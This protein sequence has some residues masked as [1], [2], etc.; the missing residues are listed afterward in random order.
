MNDRCFH[1][2][3]FEHT[4]MGSGQ[5][6]SGGFPTHGNAAR[7]QFFSRLALSEVDKCRV[8]RR[9]LRGILRM[10][11]LDPRVYERA[12]AALQATAQ[13]IAR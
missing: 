13:H 5:C 4:A 6:R 8:Y 1:C 11:G 9:A 3:H 2:R 12:R 10:Q 7:C